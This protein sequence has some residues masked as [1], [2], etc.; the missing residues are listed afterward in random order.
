MSQNVL[1][2]GASRGLGRSIACAFWKSGASLIITARSEDEL[3]SLQGELQPSAKPAQTVELITA[4]LNSETAI[5][6]LILQ[7]KRMWDHIDVLVNNAAV[8]G[9][10]GSAWEVEWESWL[11]TLNVNLLAPVLLCRLCV[12][13][14]KECGRGK[15]I[16]I[17]GGGATGPRPRFSPYATAKVGLVRFTETLAMEVKEFNIQVN[18]VAPG[19]MNSDMTSAVLAAGIVRAGEKEY[20]DAAAQRNTVK[21]NAEKAANLCVYISSAAGDLITGK[22]IS[23]VWDSWVDLAGHSEDLSSSDIYTLRRIVPKDRGKSWS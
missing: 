8:V 3:K 7:A 4:D 1:I 14:M 5:S 22:L 6:D 20:N 11:T 21:N 2:T 23:A 10:I 9:P 19:M 16:N 15:I 13:W 17:S 12:P 18:A